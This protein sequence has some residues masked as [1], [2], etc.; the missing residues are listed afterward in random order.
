MRFDVASHERLLALMAAHMLEWAD[1]FVCLEVASLDAELTGPVTSVF[2]LTTFDT[3][4]PHHP[5]HKSV[6]QQ[7]G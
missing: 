2:V 6:G 1:G 3:Q 4:T 5:L 7:A